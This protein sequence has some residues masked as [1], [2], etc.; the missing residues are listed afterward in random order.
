M[1]PRFAIPLT[2]LTLGAC[3]SVRPLV[4]PANFITRTNPDIVY[5]V[6]RTGLVTAIASPRVRG[7]SVVG[8]S[9]ET[10]RPVGVPMSQVH[11]IAA[12][13]FDRGRTVLFG[14]GVALATGIAAYALLNGA[15]GHNNWYCDYNSSV[16]GPTGEPLCGPAQARTAD[17][18]NF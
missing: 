11:Q 18:G 15:A 4:E 1:T 7:D 17:R 14:A 12:N 3:S 16:R 5:V 8:V 2:L 13:R 6:Q 9:A 10:N